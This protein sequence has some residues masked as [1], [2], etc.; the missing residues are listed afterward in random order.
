MLGCGEQAA[1]LALKASRR[2][3]RLQSAATD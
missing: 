1:R 2:P 3:G